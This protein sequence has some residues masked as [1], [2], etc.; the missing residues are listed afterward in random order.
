MITL[1]VFFARDFILEAHSS[2]G[3]IE[4]D[5]YLI[6]IDMANH[7]THQLM[8]LILVGFTDISFFSLP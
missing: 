7:A 8:Q 1:F 3:L 2:F 5:D 6:M 4:I